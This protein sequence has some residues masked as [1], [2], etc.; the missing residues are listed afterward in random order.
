MIATPQITVRLWQTEQDPF[1]HDKSMPRDKTPLTTAQQ[2][3]VE[4]AL[5]SLTFLKLV[6]RVQGVGIA[7]LAKRDLEDFIRS[8]DRANPPT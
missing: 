8:A 1:Q 5:E 7:K 2:R 3:T 6:A 4:S